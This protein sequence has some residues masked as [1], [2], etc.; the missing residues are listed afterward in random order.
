MSNLLTFLSSMNF[1]IGPIEA[2]DPAEA[3][4]PIDSKIPSF[5]MLKKDHF[6]STHRVYTNFVM[7]KDYY[8]LYKFCLELYH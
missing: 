8:G 5:S 4:A 7:K 3:T 2:Y 6:E 1:V